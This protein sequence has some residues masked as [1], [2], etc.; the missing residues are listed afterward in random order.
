MEIIV[1]SLRI[2]SADM[3]EE[4]ARQQ[5]VPANSF[6]LKRGTKRERE[7]EADEFGCS[8]MMWRKSEKLSRDVFWFDIPKT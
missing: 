5:V 8:T 2:S 7:N 1:K 4:S 6:P 3:V